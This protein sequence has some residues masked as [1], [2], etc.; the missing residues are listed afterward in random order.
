MQLVRCIHDIGAQLEVPSLQIV[1]SWL[2][3]IERIGEPTTA[4]GRRAEKA[5]DVAREEWFQGGNRCA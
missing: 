2:G 4:V 1:V 5:W 3:L